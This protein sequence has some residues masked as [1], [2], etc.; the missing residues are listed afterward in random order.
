MKRSHATVSGAAPRHDGPV[1][2]VDDLRTVL[3]PDQ[4]IAPAPDALL[5]DWFG[6][7]GHADVLVRPRTTEEVAAAL[8][9]AGERRVAVV[10]VG[11][12]TGLVGG[13]LLATAGPSMALSLAGLTECEVDAAGSTALVGAGV[14]VADLHAAA[15]AADLTYGVD[16]ASRDSATVGGTIATNAGGIHVCAYGTTRSQV[17]GLE[18]VLADGS[19]LSDLRGLPK[20][21]T[22]YALRDLV[23][24]SEGTLAVITRARLR[25]HPAP[26]RRLLLAAPCDTL[27]DCV[28]LGRACGRAAP[29]LSCECVDTASWEAAAVALSQRDPLAGAPGT[30]RALVEIDVGSRGPAAVLTEMAPTL[31]LLPD[32]A[33]AEAGADRAALWRLREGQAEWWNLVAA[34]DSGA[35]LFKFDITLPLADLDAAFTPVAG[36]LAE[37]PAVR[38]WGVFG[39]VFEGSLHL[40]FTASPQPDLEE[41]ILTLVSA[42]GGSLSAEHGV[43]RDKAGYLHLRRSPPEL[44]AMRSVKD[45]LDPG[46]ILNP[47][48]I[49][50]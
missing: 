12:N 47:G 38:R 16:L 19:V 37:E 42:A 11:G 5:T 18:V 39:H 4:V 45:A 6:R 1:A 46:G 36:L 26:A 7:R 30:Y 25:L 23:I 28:A 41:R 20:D 8:T 17:L 27:L 50:P 29:L 35:E 9:M 21:N 40:Q 34:Q 31:E 43:G 2:F 48:V 13:T 32:V 14:T 24:G 3:P 44:A 22:G 10:P 33:V 15:A 49:L